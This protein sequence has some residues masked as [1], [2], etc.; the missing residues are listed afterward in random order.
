M[1]IKP[2]RITCTMMIICCSFSQPHDGGLFS[3]IM[4]RFLP[5]HFLSHLVINSRLP[6]S[7]VLSN[8]NGIPAHG[9]SNLPYTSNQHVLPRLLMISTCVIL[10]SFCYYYLVIL[11][12]L[13]LVLIFCQILPFLLRRH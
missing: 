8:I 12:I 3:V 9:N 4:R 13:Y 1:K 10:S 7:C 11:S 6:S 2:Y 5:F